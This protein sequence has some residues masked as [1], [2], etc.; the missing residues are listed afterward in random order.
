MKYFTFLISFSLF[1]SAMAQLELVDP[2]RPDTDLNNTTIN[3][4]GVPA[5]NDL[6]FALS[7]INTSS[8]TYSIKCRRTEVDVLSGTTNSTCWVLCPPDVN[9]G[10]YPV[11][12]IGQNGF[13][14]EQ[15]MA[16]GDTA[17][18]FLAHYGPHNID[19]CSLFKYEFFDAADPATAL[20][21]IFGRFTHNVS[22]SCTASLEE[23]KSVNLK[24][25]PNPASEVVT[26]ELDKKNVDLNIV[27]LLGKTVFTQSNV[28]NNSQINVSELKNGVYFISVLKNGIVLKTE[29]LIVKH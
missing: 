24:M 5:D 8:Q 20:A 14:L 12:V 4:S 21:T 18:G 2:S 11:M 3:V 16:P 7:V 29:K 26:L 9:A 19:G 17:T 15:S 25:Y 22:T 13:E 27:D 28:I 1:F 23:V 10:D 6:D